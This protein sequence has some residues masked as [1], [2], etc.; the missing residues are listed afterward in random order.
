M[1]DMKPIMKDGEFEVWERVRNQGR[2]GLK[3]RTDKGLA[4][5]RKGGSRQVC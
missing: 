5:Q 1:E 2:T 4:G 3:Q